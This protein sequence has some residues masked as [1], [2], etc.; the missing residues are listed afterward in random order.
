[1]VKIKIVGDGVPYVAE[2]EEWH[3]L[4]SIENG[5]CA[6]YREVEG[7]D[8]A[9]QLSYRFR[10]PRLRSTRSPRAWPTRSTSRCTVW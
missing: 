5:H 9:V 3:F 7:D 2:G 8:P 4:V 1:M 6:W 10:G